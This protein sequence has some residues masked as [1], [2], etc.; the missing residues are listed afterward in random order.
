MFSDFTVLT[1]CMLKF[2]KSKTPLP[3]QKLKTIL[4]I[5]HISA[6]AAQ[7]L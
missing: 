3:N 4:I 6:Y 5:R 7:V 1:T 2:F